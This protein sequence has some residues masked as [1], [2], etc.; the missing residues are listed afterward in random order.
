M[1]AIEGIKIISNKITA[2]KISSLRFMLVQRTEG[3]I[4]VGK[5]NS[6]APE[7]SPESSEKNP[8]PSEETP[9]PSEKTPELSEKTPEAPENSQNP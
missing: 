3:L 4:V 8:E 7:N 9:K 6:T 2:D 1:E 5:R